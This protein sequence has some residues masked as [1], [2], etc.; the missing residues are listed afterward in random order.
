MA[1]ATPTMRPLNCWKSI[2]RISRRRH[3][4]T[5]YLPTASAVSRRTSPPPRLVSNIPGS[6]IVAP[7]TIR[8]Y[9]PPPSTRKNFPTPINDVHTA[10]LAI[11]DP[12][13]ARSRLLSKNNPDAARVGDVLLVRFKEPSST[14]STAKKPSSPAANDATSISSPTNPSANE[15][16]A[17]VCLNI[18]R[19]GVDTG[20]LLRNHFTRVGVEMWVK[21]YSPNVAGIEVVQRKERR[22]RRARL[23]YMR[24]PKH[25][26][27]NIQNVVTQYLKTTSLVRSGNI[28]GRKASAGKKKSKK[29]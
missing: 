14:S 9:P 17:G 28:A 13:G 19:R 2:I 6:S 27:G 24:K 26:R 12:T 5:R 21:I 16:Y 18:R 3:L 23:Y 20:I 4:S 22:A 11:L 15:S 1:S 29:T 8:T 7:K 25:D 10:Q